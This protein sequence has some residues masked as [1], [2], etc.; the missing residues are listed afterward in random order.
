[1]RIRTRLLILVLSVLV[2]S[3]I[4]AALAV[5]YVYREEQK[6]Q[7]QNV[8]EATRA[9]ALLVDNELQA[10]A[11]ILRTLAGAP[12]LHTGNLRQFYDFSRRMAPTGETVIVLSDPAGRQLVNTRQPFGAALP[13]RRSSNL[14]EL[15]RSSGAGGTLVSDAFMAPIGKRFDYAIQV[16]VVVDG[17]IRYFLVMGINVAAL[18]PMVE[19]Q[20]RSEWIAT[21]VDRQG[22]VLARSRNPERYVG[23]RASAF[24]RERLR[25]ARE[26]LWQSQTLDGIDVRAFFN[27]VPTS[28]WKVLVSIP[29]SEIQRVPLQ[30]AALLGGLMA[31]LL[32]AGVL[33]A[34]R[35]AR[36]AIGPIEYLGRSADELG[37]GKEPSYL[38]QGVLEID[39]VALRMLDAGRQI[40]QSQQE[41]EQ[42]VAEAVATT[43]RVQGALLKAQKL[44]ALGRLTGGIAHE[45][46][47]LLQTLTTALQLAEMTTTQPRVQHLVQTCKKTVQRATA[48]TGQLG[49]FGR[50]QEA[51]RETVAACSQLRSALQLV[52]GA[53]RTDIVLEVDC[54]EPAW[55]VT[56]E[57]LQFDLALLNLAINA[58]DAMPRGGVLR[59]AARNSVL[60]QPPGPLP[61][62]DY[63]RLSVIDHGAGM[64]PEVLARALD[65]FYTTKAQG[66]GTGLGLPQA[67]AFAAQSQGLLVLDSEPGKGTRVDIYLPRAQRPLCEPAPE[68][69]SDPL[70]RGR[71]RVLF[72]E[73]DPL[74]RE[75]VARA[76]EESGFEV[77]IAEDGDQ[78]VALLDAGV[79][80]AVVFSDIVMPG[81]VSGIDLA[82][83]VRRR[84]PSLP[85]VLAT[86]YTER[87]P[88]LPGVQ[89]LAKPY[90]LERLVTLLANA[91][92][93]G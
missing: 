67:Y 30:A 78:A 31:A 18:Q 38:R 3:F 36:R 9:F 82:A 44:E 12:S 60:D 23:Q 76:L 56:V 74:V 40:R 17:S 22:T 14:G 48:L 63:V 2:P 50:I 61:A 1:M 5:A 20:F 77:L 7:T 68:D 27:T 57:P 52:K 62:G 24:A 42:R 32:A 81:S 47:N 72:V 93:N 55:P 88:A 53:L 46:N 87:Q 64:A 90:P 91:T 86:G 80:P 69:G 85:V 79:L 84:F 49:S 51:R 8:A 35:M 6:S 10:R 71:G 11:G 13:Q 16:P 75:A 37:Q 25:A 59:I 89:V 29:D 45:F 66:Q 43:E 26:G 15:I 73:D 4:A 19:R 33:A 65:P 41:L 21:L 54:D 28:G 39:N 58:R 34:H 83:I 92:S 70:P